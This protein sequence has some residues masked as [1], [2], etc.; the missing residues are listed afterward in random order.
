V[1]RTK[2]PAR[3]DWYT[4]RRLRRFVRSVYALETELD[5]RVLAGPERAHYRHLV[6]R[7]RQLREDVRWHLGQAETRPGDLE[8]HRVRTQWDD[9]VRRAR[10]SCTC[11]GE[12]ER[13]NMEAAERAADQHLAYVYGRR[14][15]PDTPPEET[16]P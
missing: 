13:A 15:Y 12:G 3:P 14:W 6:Q 11:G 4:R 7:A 2:R 1:S 16:T 8:R 5:L 10:W 9:V